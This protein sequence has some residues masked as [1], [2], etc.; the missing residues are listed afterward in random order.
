MLTRRRLLATAAATPPAAALAAGTTQSASAAAAS[1]AG[2][3]I[4]I[5]IT[6]QQRKT[7]HF[8][9]GWAREN[10]PG[11]TAPE[12]QRRQL[13][14][15]VLQLRACARRRAPRSSPGSSRRSTG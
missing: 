5:F 4:F 9:E 11:L 14:E 13:R 6:D 15:R 10:L 1:A 12:G 7:M 8:P 3:N 2:K